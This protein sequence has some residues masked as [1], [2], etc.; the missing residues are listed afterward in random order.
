MSIVSLS[1]SQSEFD[2]SF[3]PFPDPQRLVHVLHNTEQPASCF[4]VLDTGTGLVADILY[5]HLMLKLKGFYT[6]RKNN[7]V[8]CKGQRYVYGDFIIKVGSVNI[9]QNMSFKGILVE[10]RIFS[11]RSFIV[12]PSFGLSRTLVS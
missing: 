6:A 2:K 11:N 5:D 4:A 8:E 10:V 12:T 7:R 3:C 9:G 1:T